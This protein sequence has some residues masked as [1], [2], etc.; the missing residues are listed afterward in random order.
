MDI[1]PIVN[2]KRAGG[3]GGPYITKPGQGLMPPLT[4]TLV[5]PKLA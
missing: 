1:L 5:I 3:G 4:G 2:W